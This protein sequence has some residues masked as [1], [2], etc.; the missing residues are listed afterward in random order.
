MVSMNT[1]SVTCFPLFCTTSP[2]PPGDETGLV[3]SG[4]WVMA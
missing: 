4:Q 3:L 1:S 2:V